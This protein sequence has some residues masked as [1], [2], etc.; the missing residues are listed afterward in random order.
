MTVTE[1]ITLWREVVMSDPTRLLQ[2]KDDMT[3]Y[4]AKFILFYV[5]FFVNVNENISRKKI[6]SLD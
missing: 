2:T 3:T 4:Y 6:A 5:D 1:V